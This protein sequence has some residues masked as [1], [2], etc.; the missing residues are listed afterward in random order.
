MTIAHIF[1][2]ELG[3]D[4]RTKLNALIDQVA[5]IPVGPGG[6]GDVVGPSSAI[7]D[8]IAVYNGT[9]GK[10]IKDG[11][12]TIAA[13]IAAA[14]AGTGNVVGPASATA[15]GFAVYS[16][17][18]GKLIK[19]HAAT[20]NLATEVSGNLPVGNLNSGTLA[21]S[22]TFWRGD[23]TWATPAA[24]GGMAIG[25]SIASATAGSVLFAGAAGVLAQ[26]NANF[27]WDDTLKLYLGSAGTSAS[28]YLNAVPGIFEVPNGSGN[29]WFEGNAGNFTLTGSGN[30][31]TGDGVLSSLTT[32]SGNMAIGGVDSGNPFGYSTA[33]NITT[34][35]AGNVGNLAIGA[36]ALA[37][38]QTGNGN[39]AMGSRSMEATSYDGFNVAIGSNC[40][41]KLGQAGA[42][43]GGNSANIAI[44]VDAL[45]NMTTGTGVIA[46]GSAAAQALV[47]G[48]FGNSIFIGHGVMSNITSVNNTYNTVIGPGAGYSMSGC[49]GNTILGRWLGAS[50]TISNVIALAYGNNNLA[51]DYNFTTANYWTAFGNF[52]LSAGFGYGV[53]PKA[54]APAAGD[55]TVGTFLVI[56]DTSAGQTWLVFNKAGTIR[57]VQ[58]T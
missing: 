57:K 45:G 47:S 20:I 9:T 21:S 49:E 2:G 10:L 31:G 7:A 5:A 53:V 32:G 17:T 11:G 37:Q 52:K 56:D 39:V 50:G 24:G 22:T 29:N 18:T 12:Q 4:V 44:A 38:L 27:R 48:G 15:N 25:G 8:S 1:N 6:S 13:V 28:L 43:S 54:G 16:G 40:M 23:G 41:Q 58:L 46:I 35:G 14:I 33:R 3:F 26:N 51:M 19:D 42:G 55:L 30:F 36:S 34:G